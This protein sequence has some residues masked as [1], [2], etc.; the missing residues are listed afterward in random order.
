MRKIPYDIDGQQTRVA[1]SIVIG[2]RDDKSLSEIIK[3]YWLPEEDA[4]YWWNFFG[5]E[6][7][8]KRESKKRV[9]K[10]SAIDQF[11]KSNIGKTVSAKSICSELNITT[12]TFYN[13]FNKNRSY[14]KKASKGEYLI[15]DPQSLRE[16]ENSVEQ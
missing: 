5:F 13:Y 10:K 2:V 15:I 6:G 8:S 11:I 14:F 1:S 4:K 9:G 3:Y 12:P 7:S 16:E